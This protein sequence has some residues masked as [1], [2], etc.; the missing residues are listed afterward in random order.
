MGRLLSPPPI[1][2]RGGTRGISLKGN[3]PT[4]PL[5][6]RGRLEQSREIKLAACSRSYGAQPRVLRRFQT[7]VRE[8]VCEYPRGLGH[9]AS[10]C[11]FELKTPPDHY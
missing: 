7:S 11:E 5:E 8:A 3:T 10:G 2:V 9:H 1:T 4:G 6:G